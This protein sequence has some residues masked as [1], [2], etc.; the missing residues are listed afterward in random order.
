MTHAELHLRGLAVG[1]DA[2]PVLSG[3]DLVV[4]SGQTLAMLGES[5][6]GKSTLLRTIAGILAPLAGEVHLGGRNLAG[7]PTHRR[8]VGMVFQGHA[9]FPHASVGANVAF[10]ARL[11]GEARAARRSFADRWLSMVG[12]AGM[13][14]RDVATLSG[15]QRQRVALAR[16]LAA[17]PRVLLLDE[18]LGALDAGLRA[19]LLGDLHRLFGEL[20][21]TV[22]HVTHDPVEAAT[23]AGT[24]ALVDAGRIAQVGTPSH[25]HASPSS[26]VAARLL[27]H[28]NVIEGSALGLTP[29]EGCTHAVIAMSAL[30]LTSDTDSASGG[31]PILQAVTEVVA[32]GP[33]W[34]LIVRTPT[35]TRLTLATTPTAAPLP[36]ATVGVELDLADITWV[37]R[38]SATDTL[39]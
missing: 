8:E 27:G 32:P 36:G 33:V 39:T 31:R 35:G 29:A 21:T 15:G 30:R 24:M 19:E 1:W 14:D 18:P 5:G 16:A 26:A 22:V 37:P 11:R 20:E 7:V 2:T 12:L 25:L 9:L 34:T 23:L 28:P 3:V 10:S 6:S 13:A 17:E 4:P 38:H